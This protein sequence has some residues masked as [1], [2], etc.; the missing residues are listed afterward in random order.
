MKTI[1]NVFWVIALVLLGWGSVNAQLWE[2]LAGGTSYSIRNV[3]A[4][5]ISKKLY[6]VGH[7]KYAGDT[8]VLGIAE[9]DGQAFKCLGGGIPDPWYCLPSNYA[10]CIS[11]SFIY[12]YNNQVFVSGNFDTIGGGYPIDGLARWDG[13]QWIDCGYHEHIIMLDETHGDLFGFGIFHDGT[14]GP[15]QAFGK[16]NGLTFGQFG[17]QITFYQSGFGPFQVEFYK[18]EYYFGGNFQEPNGLKEIMRWNGASWLPVQQGVLGDAQVSVMRVFKDQLFVGGPFYVADG[19]PADNLMAWDGQEWYNPFPNVLFQQQVNKM[20]IIG[21]K[22]YMVGTHYVQGDNGWEGPYGIAHYDGNEFCSFGGLNT[23]PWDVAGFDNEIFVTGGM[24]IRLYDS[25]TNSIGD[26]IK[27]LGHW[28]GG[29]STDICI[30]QPVRVQDPV[31]TQNPTISLYPNPSNSSFT[32]TL[33]ANTSTCTLKI[34][35]ITGREVAASRTYRAGDPPVD[36]T[37]LSAGLYFVE[38]QI[39]DRVEVIKLVK[40]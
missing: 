6:L 31:W 26:T 34:H 8:M 4:D 2:P 20:Q 12:S 27:F 29:D 7:F 19:N 32:L 14:N 16:W 22:L 25:L 21:G 3:F 1:R 40:Q 37:H 39:K 23:Y 18:G 30:S 15:M 36:V 35:D 17:T 28:I 24:G 38:V 13:S 9:W 11:P 10:V 5:S 33:P